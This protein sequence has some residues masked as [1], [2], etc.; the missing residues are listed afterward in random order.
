MGD[1]LIEVELGHIKELFTEKMKEVERRLH[2]LEEDDKKLNAKI[3]EYNTDQA[4]IMEQLKTISEKLEDLGRKQEE[5]LKCPKP[6]DVL[7]KNKAGMWDK[8]TSTAITTIVGA[9]I[10]ALVTLILR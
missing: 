10:G 5:F 6:T 9:L 4:K 8:I 2:D 7:N 3:N 1:N